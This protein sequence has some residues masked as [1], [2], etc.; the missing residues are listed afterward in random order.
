MDN[1]YSKSYG[2]NVV[3]HNSNLMCSG[4]IMVFDFYYYY[5]YVDMVMIIL[6]SK[7]MSIYY[8]YY[9]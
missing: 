6:P 4:Y 8:P 7:F 3:I 5:Y 1:E 9:V 2:L